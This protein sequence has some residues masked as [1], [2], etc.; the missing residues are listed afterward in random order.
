MPTIFQ[1][2]EW[3]EAEIAKGKGQLHANHPVCI[4][5]EQKK[6]IANAPD[7]KGMRKTRIAWDAVDP[8]SFAEFHKEKEKYMLAAGGNPVLGTDAIIMALRLHPFEEVRNFVMALTDTK[9]YAED[10]T[11]SDA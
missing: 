5:D 1:V 4:E 8:D 2:K 6:K 11:L 7:E 10:E 3:A 9:D